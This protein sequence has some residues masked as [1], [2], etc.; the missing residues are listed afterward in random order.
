MAQLAFG[1][2]PACC[3]SGC[4]SSAATGFEKSRGSLLPTVDKNAG[5]LEFCSVVVMFLWCCSSLMYLLFDAVTL[6][7]GV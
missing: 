7:L 5:D 6:V 4:V 2:P 3:V 1:P